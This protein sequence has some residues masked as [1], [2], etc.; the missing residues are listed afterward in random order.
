MGMPED[1]EQGGGGRKADDPHRTRTYRREDAEAPEAPEATPP[2]EPADAL[3]PGLRLSLEVIEGPDAGRILEIRKP[4]VT[5]GRGNAD[6]RLQDRSVSGLHFIVEIKSGEARLRDLETTNGTLLNGERC[7]L[8][9]LHTQDEI[10]VGLT[11]IRFQV[12]PASRPLGAA[13]AT[14]PP[15]SGPTPATEAML[16]KIPKG[17]PADGTVRDGSHDQQAKV[18]VVRPDTG[19]F[20][21]IVAGSEAG[22]VFD[23]S[24]PGQYLIGRN[25]GEVPLSDDKC[26]AKHAQIQILAAEEYFLID[27][28]STNGTYLN[29]IRTGRRRLKHMDVIRIGDTKMRFSCM[30]GTIPLAR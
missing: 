25:N 20:L 3:P 24:Q 7:D 30:E 14:S 8:A 23:L 1:P 9:V 19:I 16:K 17:L 10:Q 6:F 15:P 18:G 26:S 2:E 27:L 28:A 5:V 11:K 21:E 4:E 12:A 22:K 13:P 29:E